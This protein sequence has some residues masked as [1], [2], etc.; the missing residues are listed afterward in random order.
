MK[1]NNNSIPESANTQSKNWPGSTLAECSKFCKECAPYSILSCMKDYIDDYVIADKTPDPISWL[2]EHGYKFYRRPGNELRAQKAESCL[3]LVFRKID[4]G[5]VVIVEF[6]NSSFDE[7]PEG[8]SLAMYRFG[9]DAMARSMILSNRKTLD[10]KASLCT[11][12][13]P[14]IVMVMVRDRLKIEDK[15][16][17]LTLAQKLAPFGTT[18]FCN[19]SIIRSDSVLP[20]DLSTKD[21]I[22]FAPG[23][24]EA[25]VN[26]CIEVLKEADTP[27]K[28]AN[29][30]MRKF[31]DIL[32]K[33]AEGIPPTNDIAFWGRNLHYSGLKDYKP[34]I[35]IGVPRIIG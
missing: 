17:L 28:L 35:E 30:D 32:A 19:K 21:Y 7:C 14:R 3:D 1:D 33:K 31:R 24:I 18:R 34:V 12:E 26:T 16:L 6:A 23:E 27:E 20:W 29:Y 8:K 22:C 13:M 9:S 2:K 25:I 10:E 11:C 15:E 5:A 4:G